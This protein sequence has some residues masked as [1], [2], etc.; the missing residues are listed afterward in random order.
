M[1]S[2]TR[3]GTF[4]VAAAAITFAPRFARAQ[5]LTKVRLS[6]SPDHDIIGAL[7]GVQSGIFAKYG[8]DVDIR[9]ANSGAVV[10]AAVIGGA[11]DIGKGSLLSLLNAHSKG[12]SLLLEAPASTWNTDAPDSALVVAKG[13]SI[14][15]G[16]DLNGK[17][18]SVP[19][20][21]DLYQISISAW[22]DQ[23]GG[24][25][26]TVKFLELPHRAAA[27]SIAAGRVDAA[28]IAEPILHDALESGKCQVLGRAQDGIAKHFIVTSYFCTAEYAAKN[29]DVLARF[30]R[31]LYEA[32]AYSNANPSEM[33]PVLAKY[34]GVE[35]K[36]IA[37]M[38][39]A[40]VA[41]SP[42]QL[43]PQLIQPIIDAAVKYRMLA[44]GFPA[45]DM[46][47]PKALG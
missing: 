24:D 25:A 1:M 4:I 47:D 20:L 16:R 44:A 43:D 32:A 27:E 30:R 19:A 31:G 21:G 2:S 15:N 23:H 10:A 26:R 46:L 34:S 41:T 7:W 45:K 38:V 3:R 37:S 14:R 9:V 17:T 12:V 22:I 42:K 36:T 18:I 11:L 40:P 5:G 35:A 29:A 28:N 33:V 8:L 13:S 6:G 39:W